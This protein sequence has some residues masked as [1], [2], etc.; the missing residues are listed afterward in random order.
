M[1]VL[2]RAL[3]PCLAFLLAMSV[4][5]CASTLTASSASAAS[6]WVTS[7]EPVATSSALIGAPVVSMDEAGDSTELWLQSEG[8]GVA[9]KS[10]TREDGGSWTPSVT[11]PSEGHANEPVLAVSPQGQATA[12]WVDYREGESPQVWSSQ[13]A[14]GGA[15]SAAVR[16]GVASPQRGVHGLS[17]VVDASGTAV[18]AWYEYGEAGEGQWL[19][20]DTR[21]GASW[22][23]PERISQEAGVQGYEHPALATDGHGGF[24]AIWAE[25]NDQYTNYSIVADEMREGVWQ[26]DQTLM[27]GDEQLG[28]ANIAENAAGEAT[29]LWMNY[30]LENLDTATLRG[31]QWNVQVIESGSEDNQ[32]HLPQPQVGIDAVGDSTAAWLN[33]AGDV[34]TDT[35]PDGGAWTGISQLTDFPEGTVAQA[36]SLGE[37]PA[38]G[39]ALVW[40]RWDY[41]QDMINVEGTYRT[42][43]QTWETPVGISTASEDLSEP[44]LAMDARGDALTSWGMGIYEPNGELSYAYVGAPPASKPSSGASGPTNPSGS[45][46]VTS[47][48]RGGTESPGLGPVY[49]VV[50]HS[51][52]RLHRGSRTLTATIRNRN[53][54]P[55][56]GTA[57]LSWFL[58]PRRGAHAA[59]S[60]E[61]TSTAIATIAHFSL[62][63]HG[64]SQVR[65]RLSARALR[66]LRAYVPDSGHDLVSIRLVVRGDGEHSS[67]ATVYA[68]DAPITAGVRHRHAPVVPPGYR[69]PVDPWVKAHA[70]C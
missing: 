61:G 4:A 19:E 60:R 41:D 3:P 26:G 20:V 52:L 10:A 53:A 27:S 46:S 16:L 12:A 34:F 47:A 14:P 9:I 8:E 30:G 43:G 58:L 35:L 70:A 36:L 50:P 5:L 56:T 42:P 15:W 25:V 65:F 28:E 51:R 2:D 66:R 67:G 32:C 55:V 57:T 44:S 69:A 29:A 17:V 24:I 37:D 64:S 54:F 1:A 22:H 62:S 59:G 38:G 7:P 48:V 63:A 31:G 18:V 11:V 39:A 45:P 49:L 23:G 13:R 40:S 6:S 68:L 33:T 21:Q